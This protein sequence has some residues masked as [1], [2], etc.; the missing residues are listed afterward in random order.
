[1]LIIEINLQGFF[2]RSTKKRK[3]SD[4][5]IQ[6]LSH[7]FNQTTDNEMNKT[8]LITVWSVCALVL[9][10]SFSGGVLEFIVNRRQTSIDTIEDIINAK[11]M[12]A[13][14]RYNSWLWY[15]FHDKLEW[16][17]SLD[18]NLKAIEP[19]FQTFS[20]SQLEDKVLLISV[21]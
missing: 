21:V 6:I 4:I 18:S 5:V 20:D 17:K 1:M 3:I 11:N 12:S 13:A 8:I 19:I 10:S 15:Q 16:N 14:I 9:T 7:I 2:N